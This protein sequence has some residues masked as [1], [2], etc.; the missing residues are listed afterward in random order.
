MEHRVVSLRLPVLA[1]DALLIV[2]GVVV[3]LRRR[4]P[5]PVFVTGLEQQPKGQSR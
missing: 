5:V 3:A 4:W 1:Q 2:S